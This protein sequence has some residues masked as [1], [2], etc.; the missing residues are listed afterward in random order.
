MNQ[1][2]TPEELVEGFSQVHTLPEIY[3]R[4]KAVVDSPDA[5]SGDLVREISTDPGL[6]GR[7]LRVVN[8]PLYARHGKVDSLVRAVAVLGTRSIHDLVLAT[9][10]T[11]M[12][13]RKSIGGFDLR[14]HWRASLLASMVTRAVGEFLRSRDQDRLFVAGL[15]SR[16]GELVMYERASGVALVVAKHAQKK[17]LALHRVQRNF[18]G[19][20]YG[21]VG[22]ALLRKWSLPSSLCTAVEKHL[23]APVDGETGDVSVLRTG[24]L[25]CAW[26]DCDMPLEE[27]VES[28]WGASNISLQLDAS[29]L[30]EIHEACCTELDAV[31]QAF[32]PAASSAA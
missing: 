4:I 24:A 26:K 15:L 12:I 11:G 32:L 21:E 1:R 8:S 3:L 10:V 17:K 22:A 27:F 6:S 29:R 5:Q 9:A 31:Q 28:V 13:A 18:L 16:I 20:H 14:Q 7:V 25:V 23:D 2:F 30:E 19:C